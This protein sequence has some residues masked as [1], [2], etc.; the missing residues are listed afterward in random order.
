M[1]PSDQLRTGIK[2]TK[3]SQDHFIWITTCGIVCPVRRLAQHAIV[4]VGFSAFVATTAIAVLS[5]PAEQTS[6]IAVPAPAVAISAPAP[7]SAA[8]QLA[9]E[10][11]AAKVGANREAARV[12]ASRCQ[13]SGEAGQL[14]GQADQG[15]RSA[16]MP[17]SRPSGRL[18]RRRRPRRGPLAPER[19]PIVA[20]SRASPIPRRW[21]GRS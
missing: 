12:A 4:G 6:A 10:R 15:H 20:T 19:L 8:D 21:P 16:S 7:A 2:H 17:R 13:T 11:A 1:S 3:W 18:L 9:A 5:S 14:L